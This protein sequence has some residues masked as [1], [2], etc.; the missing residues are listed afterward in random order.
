MFQ[1]KIDKI[2]KHLPNVF[3]IADEILV[4]CYD[5]DGK[6]NDGTLQKVLKICRHVHLKLH[7]EKC[8][9]MCTS[10]PFL[11]RRYLGME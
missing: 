7:K 2:F 6:G 4:I 8:H 1:R 11:E 5:S 9:F 10:D 3:G